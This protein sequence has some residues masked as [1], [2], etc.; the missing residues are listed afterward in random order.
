MTTQ[1]T[2]CP[3]CQTSFRVTDDQLKIA[4]GAVRCG[5]CLHIFNAPEH[6]LG[7]PTNSPDLAAES[8]PF[9]QEEEFFSDT[10]EQS[11]IEID[12]QHLD[13]I[14]PTTQ[15]L[16]VE[17]NDSSLNEIDDI[18]DDD[19]FDDDTD[20]LN[21]TFEEESLLAED[22]FEQTPEIEE[23]LAKVNDSA[24]MDIEIDEELLN[25]DLLNEGALAAEDSLITAEGSLPAEGSLTTAEDSFAI[26]EEP[27]NDDEIEDE[28]INDEPEHDSILEIEP[29]I[30]ELSIN[31][32][33]LDETAGSI[34][35]DERN[36]NDTRSESFSESFLNID[37]WEETP[38]SKVFQDLDELGDETESEEEWAK[39]LL[40]ED[41]AESDDSGSNDEEY[42]ADADEQ[43]EPED[44]F[45]DFFDSLDDNEEQH[46][47]VDPELLDIIDEQEQAEQ[48]QSMTEFVFNEESLTAGDRIGEEKLALLAGIEP[49]PVEIAT[50]SRH[51]NLT[52]YAWQAAAVIAVIALFIQYVT[53]NF[54]QLARDDSYR[55]LLTSTCN[56]IGC[57]MP[58][59]HDIKL[60]RSS[61]LMIRSNPD[62]QQ[63]LVI[64]A[65]ITNRATFPQKFPIMELVFT[66]LSGNVVAGRRFTPNEYLSGELTGS[67]MMPI[68]QPVHISLNIVDPG[69]H[70]VNYRLNFH[71]LLGG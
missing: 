22:L 11:A 44:Q 41:E 17:E 54:E 53:F 13:E 71:P 50:A 23:A 27:I 63:S 35:D 69:S 70:A 31:E 1:V 61:N 64:D 34:E 52:Q 6:W 8:D 20:F 3:K 10:I 15:F 51:H 58:E 67:N 59:K 26:D 47:P 62:Q 18:F 4:N 56:I 49:E 19:I 2:Q 7:N 12:D 9:H 42:L 40:E 16:N 33:G 46:S 43:E 28:L 55:S 36:I 14:E 60:I 68:K 38:S 30:D 48:P 37:S 29:S 24:E 66:D 65:I 45:E 57:T 39:K 25:E 5:S 21:E 32:P